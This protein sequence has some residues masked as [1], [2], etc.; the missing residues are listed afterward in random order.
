MEHGAFIEKGVSDWQIIQQRNGS[1]TI[2]FSGTWIVIKDAVKIG[3]VKVSPL[4]R[5]V[6]EEDNS[7]II[8][9]QNTIIE[10]AND[11]VTGKWSATLTIPAGG[12]YRIETGLRVTS[13]RPGLIWTFRGDTRLHVGI[14]DVF[15]IAGQ[16]NAAGTG[17]DTAYDP[18]ELGVHLFRNR[19]KW[20]LAAHPF[21]ESTEGAGAP[22]AERGV[23]GTSPYLSFGRQFK[24]ISHYPV[25]LISTAMGGMPIKRWNPDGGPLYKN[26]LEQARACGEIAGVLWYQGCSNTADTDIQDYKN[27]FYN[28]IR[29][30][31]KDLGYPVNFFIFQLNRE[32]NSPHDMGY[33]TIREV[34]RQAAHDLDH[35]YVLP[36]IHCSLSDAIHNNSHSNLMLGEHLARQCGHVL[37][38]APE[39][40]APEISS[41]ELTEDTTLTLTFSN[42]KLG[43]IIPSNQE[44]NCGFTIEDTQ[45]NISYNEIVPDPHEPNRITM[46]LS[47][48]PE[49]SCTVSFASEANPTR[50]L[51]MDEVTY[52]PPLAFYHY[53]VKKL[54]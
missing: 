10:P 41:A 15:L 24:K 22:N 29:C 36:T 51:L 19:H 53:P 43:F 20:D 35:V 21:N 25:G 12:P 16:S 33:G 54:D 4:I 34:Q 1:A 8:P 47:R 50:I 18:P 27:K 31:R 28:I 14:G 48:V 2:N 6:S 9:W 52:L 3:I 40:F 37:Y 23:S 5:V 7:Q 49:G 26:M 45:G 13:A 32:I 38:H 39:F 44:D 17:K 30:F 11:L 42:M 46:H